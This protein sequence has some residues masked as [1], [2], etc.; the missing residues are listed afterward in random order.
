MLAS[1]SKIIQIQN[2][3]LN[4]SCFAKCGFMLQKFNI[5]PVTLYI[6]LDLASANFSIPIKEKDQKPFIFLWD[7][8]QIP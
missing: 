3:C 6:A 7:E 2:F 5:V 1:G 4:S 8:K